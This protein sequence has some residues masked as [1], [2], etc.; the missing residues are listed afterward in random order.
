M[1]RTDAA[2][3]RLVHRDN[4]I[5][6]RKRLAESANVAQRQQVL[7]LLG[8]EEAKDHYNREPETTR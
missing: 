1:C 8:E 6:L 5:P 3:E 2:I 4:L 7:T